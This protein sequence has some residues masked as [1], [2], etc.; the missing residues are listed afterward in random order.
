MLIH[1][2][3][4]KGHT[5]IKVQPSTDWRALSPWITVWQCECI[6]VSMTDSMKDLPWSPPY[7]DVPRQ[8]EQDIESLSS[9]SPF[10]PRPIRHYSMNDVII[11]ENIP[12]TQK[13]VPQFN[14]DKSNI[15]C[16]P[17]FML[18]LDFHARLHLTHL[19]LTYKIT[20]QL[21]PL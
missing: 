5:I 12:N 19:S 11:T 6:T 3:S 14:I 10:C 20:S 7:P 21:I 1:Y 8:H 13:L 17:S 18:N 16:T 9:C 15:K 4:R 2:K